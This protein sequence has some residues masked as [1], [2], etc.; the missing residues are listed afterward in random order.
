MPDTGTMV[1]DS[2]RGYFSCSTYHLYE[3]HTRKSYQTN[4][5]IVATCDEKCKEIYISFKHHDSSKLI[6]FLTEGTVF[7]RL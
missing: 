5:F 1:N 3:K 6:D 4:K 7:R 2:L